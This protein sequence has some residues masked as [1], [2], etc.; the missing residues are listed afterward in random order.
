MKKKIIVQIIMILS[1]FTCIY[2]K[3][4]KNERKPYKRAT[5]SIIKKNTAS[6]SELIKEKDKRY[7]N[8]SKKATKSNADYKKYDKMEKYDHKIDDL[9]DFEHKNIKLGE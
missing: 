4:P 5:M 3:S 7:H 8:N 2:A 6:V 9:T 1:I